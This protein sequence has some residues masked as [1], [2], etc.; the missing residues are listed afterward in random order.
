MSTEN[1]KEQQHDRQEEGKELLRED[2]MR[3]LSQIPSKQLP[4]ANQPSLLSK[5]STGISNAA[6]AITEKV[7]ISDSAPEGHE[8][9]D[10]NVRRQVKKVNDEI[11]QQATEKGQNIEQTNDWEDSSLP[12]FNKETEQPADQ[13]KGSEQKTSIVGKIAGS[14]QGVTSSISQGITNIKDQI[15]GGPVVEG[16]EELDRGV[17]RQVKKVN[18][19]IRKQGVEKG[20]TNQTNDWEDSTLPKFK[21][22]AEQPAENAKSSKP[23]QPAKQET[24]SIVRKI[25]DS[26]QG[27]SNTLSQGVGSIKQIFS[28]EKEEEREEDG[29][30]H[31]KTVKDGVNETVTHLKHEQRVNVLGQDELSSKNPFQP[32]TSG[33][34]DDSEN[35]SLGEKVRGGLSDASQKISSTVGGATQ[36]VKS[37][38]VHK[39]ANAQ[40]KENSQQIA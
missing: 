5:I 4:G 31:Y 14:V 35:R 10:R 19:E 21:K 22:E 16:H 18:D 30:K 20:L 34:N 6:Y 24:T 7:G 13:V 28:K 1:F 11:R 12:K 39:E 32:L 40:D 27:V 9:L 33:S 3:D 23:E 26:V 17:R 2:E 8:D 25:S 38:F 15:T 29:T 36:K 37:V